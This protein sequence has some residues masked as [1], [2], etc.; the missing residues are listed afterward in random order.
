M[1]MTAVTESRKA[2]VSAK[3]ICASHASGSSIQN[4]T[5][6]PGSKNAGFTDRYHP[7]RSR[8]ALRQLPSR[9]CASSRR[10]TVGSC[11]MMRSARERIDGS[12][13]TW[14]RSL[15][16]HDLGCVSHGAVIHSCPDRKVLFRFSRA[17]LILGEEKGISIH[18]GSA[19]PLRRRS[20]EVEKTEGEEAEEEGRTAFCL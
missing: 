10:A 5:G 20:A 16:N 1:N 6:C 15:S 14:S 18:E 7:S 8:S 9:S 13:T 11:G 12:R 4:A 2:N 17:A 3:G 19:S